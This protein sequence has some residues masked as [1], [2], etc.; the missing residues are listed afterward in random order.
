MAPNHARLDISPAT[1]PMLLFIM[2]DLPVPHS[3]PAGG[4]VVVPHRAVCLLVLLRAL[5]DEIPG[6]FVFLVSRIGRERLLNGR[7]RIGVLLGPHGNQCLNEGI[8]SRLH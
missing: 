4:A 8:A 7:Y 2:V 3:I 6:R 1:T 5:L